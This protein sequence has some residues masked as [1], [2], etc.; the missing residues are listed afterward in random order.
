M[1]TVVDTL[2]TETTDASVV[3]ISRKQN[4]N[5]NRHV[6]VDDS[7]NI[8]RNMSGSATNINLGFVLGV[9]FEVENIVGKTIKFVNTVMIVL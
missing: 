4:T 2:N 7:E 9:I 1:K 5:E 3:I 8:R 6:F